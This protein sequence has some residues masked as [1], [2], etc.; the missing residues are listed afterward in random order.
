M[1]GGLVELEQVLVNLF[2][3]ARDA[4][5][6]RAVRRLIVRARAGQGGVTLEVAD[7]GGGIPL[8]LLSRIFDPF[9]T[10][11][12]IGKGTGLGLAICRTTM[13]SCGGSIEASNTEGGAV[14]TLQ[15][16]AAPEG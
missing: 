9:F 13:Q 15:L 14:F 11:K 6:G 12:D 2:F 4:M 7:T 1:R 3:N 10:T 16:A 8:T 5:A